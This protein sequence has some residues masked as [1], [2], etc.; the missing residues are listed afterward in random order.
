MYIQSLHSLRCYDTNYNI[1]IKIKKKK[2]QNLP[3][4]L[5]QLQINNYDRKLP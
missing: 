1:Y 3:I 2:N 5:F 4:G